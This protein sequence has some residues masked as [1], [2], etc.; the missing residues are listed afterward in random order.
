MMQAKLFAGWF[1]SL[2]GHDLPRSWQADL[3]REERCRDR[4]VRISTGLGNEECAASPKHAE[5]T[6]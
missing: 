2:T 6:I 4:L 5:E 3:A 1:S